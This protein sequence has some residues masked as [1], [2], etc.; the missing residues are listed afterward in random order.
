[1]L[2]YNCAGVLAEYEIERGVSDSP[3]LKNKHLFVTYYS[4]MTKP[5][6]H[7]LPKEVVCE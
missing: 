7:N 4:G 3:V 6:D 2:Y 5:T 1:M